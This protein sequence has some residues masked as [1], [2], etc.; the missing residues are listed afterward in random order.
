MV[1]LA[2]KGHLSNALI[3]LGDMKGNVGFLVLSINEIL[4]HSWVPDPWRKPGLLEKAWLVFF[5]VDVVL[6]M[7]T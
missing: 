2:G 4:Y 1:V 5:V 3:S 6:E 7:N